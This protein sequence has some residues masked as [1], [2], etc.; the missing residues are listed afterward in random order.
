[1]IVSQYFWPENFRINDL[2]QE[3]VVRG[4]RVTVLTGIPN[5]P[6]GH[7]YE[8]FRSDPVRF[9]NYEKV[10]IVRVPLLPRGF[11]TVR[12]LLNY[13]TFSLL[14]CA[15]GPWKLRGLKFDVVLTYQ[16]SPVTVGLPGALMAWIKNA[17]MAMWVLDLWPDTLRAIGV[18]KS[19]LLLACVGKLVG[20]I[21]RR[22]D[23]IWAQS[24]SFI[25]KI[26]ALSGPNIPIVYFPSWAEEFFKNV[27][28]RPAPEVPI[29]HGAF[30]LMFAGNVGEAQDFKCILSAA[31]LLKA[32]LNIRWLIV[33][34]GRMLS[35]VEAQIKSRGLDESVLLLGRHPVERMPE[36]FGHADAMLVTLAD[37]EIFSMTIPGKLQ[38]YLAAGMPIV[39]ALNG[40]GAE[41]IRL[42]R[43][44]L[45]CPAGNPSALAKTVMIMSALSLSER[46]AMGKNGLQFSKR[47]FDRIKI[48]D[49]AE[50]YLLGLCK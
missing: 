36:F 9:A 45:T 43:A 16:L 39:A 40:E 29:K 8:D 6:S 17:R 19:P 49:V 11:G 25:P 23:S 13:I 18:V 44:G 14:A 35:W 47:E 7:I 42:A 4:H 27:A 31:E 22:C 32:H 33:G 12:L 5:Y 20:F 37:Q 10:E 28:S 50:K 48:I 21:Y 24:Q 15:L 3:L 46:H 2:A 30:N 41:V 1:M 38:S 26:Q 34:D